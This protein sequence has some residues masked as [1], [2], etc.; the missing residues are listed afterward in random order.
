MS[1]FTL[2]AATV[3]VMVAVA[4]RPV[5]ASPSSD[6]LDEIASML[7][8]SADAVLLTTH[9]KRSSE[10]FTQLMQGMDRAQLMLG[11]RP[12]DQLQSVVDITT[13]VDEFR[14]AAAV[15]SL[16][17]DA[18][19]TPAQ[20][21]A[22]TV[23]VI[24]VRDHATFRDANFEPGETPD[25]LVHSSGFTFHARDVRQYVL[26]GVDKQ[27]VVDY[28]P[29]GA[30]EQWIRA[31]GD[32]GHKRL[33]QG[34]VVFV[35]NRR[36]TDRLAQF[37]ADMLPGDFGR[38]DHRWAMAMLDASVPSGHRGLL[39]AVFD[40]DPLA[41]I[42]REM[43][44][45][46]AGGIEAGQ[47]RSLAGGLLAGM[48]DRPHYVAA[49]VD[50]RRPATRAMVDVTA[51]QLSGGRPP[52]W[53]D[54]IDSAQVLVAQKQGMPADAFR[55]GLLSD[56]AI[57]LRGEDTRALRFEFITWLEALA[58]R[59]A[60]V[61]VSIEKNTTLATGEI[62]DVVSVDWK[63]P[64]TEPMHAPLKSLLIG[65][66]G[67]RGH[68]LLR[69]D[70]LTITL[71]RSEAS[72]GRGQSQLSSNAIVQAML[73]WLPQRPAALVFLPVAENL[74]ITQAA[75]AQLPF[76]GPIDLP[77]PAGT[78]PPIGMAVDVADRVG[79]GSG[80][81]IDVLGVTT[82]LP[83][84]VLTLAADAV[85]EAIRREQQHRDAQPA[86]AGDDE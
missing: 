21:L 68:L 15:V 18:I 67:W 48:A 63:P 65:P 20:L 61:T 1:R 36:A 82:I 42:I 52:H 45:F 62:V 40:F 31:L 25:A 17:G 4:A 70:A 27:R 72:R 26:L 13:S 59:D 54:L 84:Q 38:D 44:T 37:I 43:V 41:L 14:G 47:S 50:L 79:G 10:Q 76:I 39:T 34:E 78:L 81:T 19:S 69:D 73:A 66:F 32:E 16:D 64:A 35:A 23:F 55:G 58:T 5:A 77:Q 56:S 46:D 22:H 83:A 29:G 57:V 86:P 71:G 9:L 7:D 60:D 2:I 74:A 6:P 53:V 33:R 85:L 51:R 49:A 24:P 3:F 28:K 80:N 11:S 30:N 8:A 12:L 75:I